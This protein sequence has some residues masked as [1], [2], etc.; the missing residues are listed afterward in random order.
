VGLLGVL[1]A[2]GMMVP[3][4]CRCHSFMNQ[5]GR[6]LTPSEYWPVGGAVNLEGLTSQVGMGRIGGSDGLVQA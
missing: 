2:L 1:Q 4:L 3:Q 6:V 5:E